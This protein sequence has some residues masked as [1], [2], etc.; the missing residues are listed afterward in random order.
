[1]I[2]YFYFSIEI[3]LTFQLKKFIS[4]GGDPSYCL[5][6]ILNPEENTR[7]YDHYMDIN[8]DFSEVL[9]I[10]TSNTTFTMLD[11]LKDRLEIIDIPSYI[12]KEKVKYQY[13]YILRV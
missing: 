5:L 1:M 6:E 12:F 13:L 9:F 10:L 11:T 4:S 3:Y 8:I 2:S 7:F